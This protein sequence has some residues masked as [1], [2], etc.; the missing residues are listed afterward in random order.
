MMGQILGLDSTSAPTSVAELPVATRPRVEA[1]DLFRT[2]GALFLTR[3]V[4]HFCAPVFLFLAGTGA[5]LS[6]ARGKT[7]S[8]LAWF[9]LTRGLWLVA[10][11]FTLVHLGW[12]FNLDYRLLLGQVIWA[13]GCSMLA[14][15][16]LV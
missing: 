16:G 14:L 1:L 12:F 7:R 9:L 2:T 8:Q 3:W 4:T 15:A 5:F 13:I 11:E 6:A 10:L